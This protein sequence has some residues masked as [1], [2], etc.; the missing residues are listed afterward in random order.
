LA[1]ISGITR[2]KANGRTSGPILA[3]GVIV[4]DGAKVL[5]PIVIGENTVIGTG[6]IITKDVP[7]NSIAYGVN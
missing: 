7:P 1:Q 2:F 6:A 5:G 3:E 4:A